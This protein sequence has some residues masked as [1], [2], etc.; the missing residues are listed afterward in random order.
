MVVSQLG[1]TTS[2]IALVDDE[3]RFRA[4]EHALHAKAESTLRSYR[5][6]WEQ[7]E[8]WCAGR[9]LRSLPADPATIAMF[10][11]DLARRYKVATLGL[12]LVA[13]NQAHRAANFPIPTKDASVQA[14]WAGIRRELGVAQVQKAALSPDDLR[15]MFAHLPTNVRGARDRAMLLLGFA[16]GFRRSEIVGLTVDDVDFRTEGAVVTLRRSKTDQ[17]GA[18]RQIG[19]PFGSDPATCPVRALLGYLDAA[20]IAAGPLFPELTKHGRLMGRATTGRVVARTV[21][22]YARLAGLDATRYGGHSLRAGL[23]TTAAKNG[24]SIAS[25][26]AQT[27]HRSVAMV[28]RYIRAGTLFSDNAAAKAGL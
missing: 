28:Q 9:A 16:G 10:I 17:E 19:I 12:K 23:A 11:T 4:H 3:L 14:V 13:I 27:G 26:S 6:D 21:Q 7:F 25:I 18:G 20:A 24:A 2:A 5:S 1:S 22:R 8:L 15:S